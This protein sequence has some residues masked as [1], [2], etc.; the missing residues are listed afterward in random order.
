MNVPKKEDP[1]KVPVPMNVGMAREEGEDVGDTVLQSPEYPVLVLARVGLTPG[2][3]LNPRHA[4]HLLAPVLL[5]LRQVLQLQHA[6]AHAHTVGRCADAR[7][8]TYIVSGGVSGQALEGWEDKSI[9]GWEA[10]S[11][12][13]WV[14]KSIGMGG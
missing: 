12:E 6:T 8:S 1:P 2:P 14:A 4:V 7:R 9:E 10:T 13:G 5:I 11:I 3:Q